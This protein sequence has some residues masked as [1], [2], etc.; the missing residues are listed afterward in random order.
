MKRILLT[1]DDGIY[2]QGIL[3][4]HKKIRSLGEVTVVAPDAERSAQGHAITLSVPLRVN[5]VRRDGKF[6]GH[7]ISGTPADCVKIALMSIMKNK[8]PD[9]I[10][11]G[12]NRGPNLGVN[13]LYSGTVSGA[14]EGAILGVPSFAVSLNSFKW[15]NFQAAVDFSHKLAKMMLDKKLPVNTLLNVNVP[16]LPKS[17]IKGVRITRQGMSTFYKEDYDRR[18]DPNRRVYYWLCSYKAAVS[19]DELVDAVA[20]RDG[21]I[22]ITPLHYD[23]T[24]YKDLEILSDAGKRLFR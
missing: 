9:L 3:A 16:A 10:I 20:V 2:S 5:E 21:H 19:G 6:F 8:K 24:D 1:N 12:V 22:S 11:S 18:E 14:T 4:L 7:A 13:V 23:M 17:K 15:E